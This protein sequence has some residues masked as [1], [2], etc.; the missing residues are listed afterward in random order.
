VSPAAEAARPLAH[1]AE[2]AQPAELPAAQPLVLPAPDP[3]ERA[4]GRRTW[5]FPQD[6]GQHPRYRL[7]WWYYT[8]IVRTAEGRAFGYQATFFRQGLNPA[9]DRRGS[10]WRVGS[11]YLAHL[12]VSDLAR[13]RFVHAVQ[14][15]R[16]SLDLSGAAPDRQQVWLNGWRADPLAGNRD[17]VRLRAQNETLGIALELAAAR[18]PVLHGSGGLDRKGA[19]P[20]Q[21]SWYYSLTRLQTKGTLRVGGESWEVAGTSWMDHE[22]GTSQ[23]GADQV[24]WDWFALRLD[25]G[26]DLM[27]YRLRTADGHA[28]ATSGG[29]LLEADGRVIRLRLAD[30]APSPAGTDGT[31]VT[32]VTASAEPKQHWTSPATRAKYPVGWSLRVPRLG[33]ELTL[34]PAM[35]AQELLP[36]AGLPFGYWEGAVWVHGQRGGQPVRGEGYLELTGYAG[37]VRGAFR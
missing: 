27:L 10:A 24:G 26:A 31:D 28:S 22:F 17:G 37:D 33:L 16:D 2:A 15:G 18:P 13:G 34:E 32:D 25:S 1:A 9:P 4:A 19:G 6:H 7:E 36:G 30:A 21:A 11:L 5:S 29:T 3:F 35:E 12:A 14:A 20:G 8:G 23:L